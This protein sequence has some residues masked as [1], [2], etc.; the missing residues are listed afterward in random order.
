MTKKQLF[1]HLSIYPD[2]AL[3]VIKYDNDDIQEI[4]S[5]MIK[6]GDYGVY[7]E[8]DTGY[9]E[10][11]FRERTDEDIENGVPGSAICF[12]IETF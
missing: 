3:V 8:H 4:T 1:D 7:V 12:E 2:D 10:P 5:G 11:Y 6:D 9:C